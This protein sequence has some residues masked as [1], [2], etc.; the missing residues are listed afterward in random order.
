MTSRVD[1][2]V[3]RFNQAFVAGLLSIAFVVHWWPLVAMVGVV[4]ALARFAGPQWGVFTRAYVRFVRP[5]LPGPVE[6]EPAGPPRF[7][8]LL[9]VVFLGS[10]SVAFAVGWYPLGWG[11]AL[12]VFVLASLAAT[13]RIC[14]GCIIYERATT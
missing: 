5:R 4:L 11:I 12:A 3:P 1:V 13:T 2:N 6:T 9:G 10:A 14:L 7:A 8:Q